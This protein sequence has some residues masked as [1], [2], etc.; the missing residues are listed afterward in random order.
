[1]P[2]THYPDYNNLLISASMPGMTIYMFFLAKTPGCLK[3]SHKSVESHNFLIIRP[4]LSIFDWLPDKTG[5]DHD[6]HPLS[7]FGGWVEMGVKPAL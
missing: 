1:M 5:T 7:Y 2:N 3:P 4:I 6:P